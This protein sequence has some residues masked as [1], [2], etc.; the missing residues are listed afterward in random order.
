MNLMNQDVSRHYQRLQVDVLRR[1]NVLEKRQ[2]CQVYKS[3]FLKLAVV[4]LSI[5]AAAAC[6][7]ATGASAAGTPILQPGAPGQQTKTIDVAKATD[8]SKVGATAADVKFMQGMIGHHAQAVEM[9]ALI[10]ERTA[11][12]AMKLLGMRIQLSQE[13]EMKMMRSYLQDRGAAIPGPHAHHEPGG[14]MPGM[15]TPEQIANS[16]LEAASAGATVVHCHVRDPK[17]GQG[18]VILKAIYDAL[19]GLPKMLAKRRVIQRNRRVGTREILRV[20]STGLLEPYYEFMQRNKQ[21][22]P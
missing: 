19:R 17:T 4:L 1:S 7:S 11:T 20:M 15:L 2:S 8:L 10:N 21:P 6:K 16:A 13:D 9:V 5:G 14:M 12:P 22:T 3:A 18:K